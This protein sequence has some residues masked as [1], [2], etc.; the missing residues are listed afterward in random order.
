MFYFLNILSFL[1]CW[2]LVEKTWKRKGIS[3]LLLLSFL[4][5]KISVFIGK[6]RGF[7]VERYESKR[8]IVNKHDKAWWWEVGGSK[9]A[10]LAWRNYWIAPD[11]P[12]KTI[13]E[14][15]DIFGD[16][17]LSN[18]NCWINTSLYSSLLKRADLTPL[19]KKDS[20]SAKKLFTHQL[21]YC[22]TSPNCMN[23]LCLNKC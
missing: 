20:K 11:T 15:P 3:L 22:Q 10:I 8:V 17:I 13:K 2:Y 23:G 19:H 6:G 4:N 21:V 1:C 12:S 9:K 18:L 7:C 16:F 5:P 14:N